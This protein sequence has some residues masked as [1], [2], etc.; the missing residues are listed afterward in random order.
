MQS[1]ANTPTEYIAELPEDRRKVINKLREVILKNLPEGFE[2]IM[3]YGMLGYVVPHSR[4]PDGYHCN[5]SE[6]LPFMGLA[7]QKNH[8]GFYHMA[9]YCEPKILEWFTSEYSRQVTTKLDMGKGCIRLKNPDKIPYELL[10]ELA[11]KMTVDTWITT[12]EQRLKK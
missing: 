12:Y 2:E 10:G 5:P 1:K 9:L 4:Y 11:G 6:P 3:N 7:S 8:I